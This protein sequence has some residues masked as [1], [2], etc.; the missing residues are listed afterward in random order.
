M[1]LT[2]N[3]VAICSKKWNQSQLN[4]PAYKKELFGIV[5]SLR[6]F[7]AYVWGRRDLVIYTDHKPLTHMLEQKELSVALQQWLDVLLSYKFEIRY[8]PGILN[9]LPDA[10]SR[11]FS[12]SYPQTW[13]IPLPA[14]PAAA[15]PSSAVAAEP[16][17]SQALLSSLW[18]REFPS[19]ASS[20]KWNWK[21]VV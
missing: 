20:Y 2:T 4:Y 8:R 5:Y 1:T 6:Q 14:A 9:I 12:S 21:N 17:P 18:G 3:I 19:P 16:R 11:M 10:L 7:H 15:A 13:G